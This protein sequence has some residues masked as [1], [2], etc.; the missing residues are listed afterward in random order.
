MEKLFFGV[1]PYIAL[2]I[3]VVGCWIRFDHEQYTWKSDS[4]Q[5][6][7]KA[8]MRLFSN[9]FHIG[10]IAIFFGHLVGL[11]VPHAVFQALGVSDMAH[12]YIA[13]GAGAVFGGLAL[14]GVAGLW[15]RRMFNQRVRATSRFMDVF[16]LTWIA[17]TL[18]L[19]LSTLPVSISHA[20]HGNAGVMIALAEWVQ[21]IIYLH[22]SPE[23][24]AEVDTIF[25]LHLFF[26]MTVFALFPF[27][28]L[29]HIWSAPIGYLGRAYQVVRTKRTAVY[30][31]P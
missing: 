4:S 10:V 3:F 8:G 18:L 21:S 28:R 22:P 23:Y 27:S 31:K 12:Q 2:T 6:L 17:A 30:V 5:L 7:S 9:L 14:I 11:T 1:Y 13:I 20:S 16:V 29:V 19:G 26:G 25:K 15:M 24:L